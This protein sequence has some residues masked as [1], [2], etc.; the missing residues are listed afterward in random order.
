MYAFFSNLALQYQ[1][2]EGVTD[3]KKEGQRRNIS[4]LFPHPKFVPLTNYEYNIGLVQVTTN[5]FEKTLIIK[6][7]EQPNAKIIA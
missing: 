2:I 5:I 3:V 4:A 6:L 7:V 1:V